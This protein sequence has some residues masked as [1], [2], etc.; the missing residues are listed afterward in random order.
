MSEQ[1]LLINSINSFSKYF[2]FLCLLLIWLN[3]YKKW[4][5]YKTWVKTAQV[6]NECVQKVN[7]RIFK[8]V[9]W[10]CIVLQKDWLTVSPPSN[11]L[12]SSQ[13]WRWF[14]STPSHCRPWKLMTHLWTTPPWK[15][16]W[17][18]TATL[19]NCWKWAVALMFHL[20][21]QCW[22]TPFYHLQHL[23]CVWVYFWFGKKKKAM[24]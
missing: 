21:V 4:F 1:V 13:R 10:T 18:I 9:R 15:S 14:S 16:W 5:L 11:S 3:V 12:T 19:W 22:L 2:D 23:S 6:L 17:P 7:K 8:A 24:I 20:Q